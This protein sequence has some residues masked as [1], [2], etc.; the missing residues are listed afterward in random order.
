MLTLDLKSDGAPGD[1]L[2]AKSLEFNLGVCVTLNGRPV[3][4]SE[5]APAVVDES[6]PVF[7][8]RDTVI[9]TPQDV[10]TFADLL[11]QQIPSAEVTESSP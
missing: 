10:G 3:A 1:V 2:L 9:L 8:R 7:E 11:N 6:H 5:P 4:L